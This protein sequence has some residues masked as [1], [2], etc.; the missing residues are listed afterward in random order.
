MNN[1]PLS[2]DEP[3]VLCRTYV[4]GGVVRIDAVYEGTLRVCE[5]MARTYQDMSKTHRVGPPRVAW[6]VYPKSYIEKL[7]KW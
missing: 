3:Y 4:Q 7:K 6:A 5:D 2:P 1:I